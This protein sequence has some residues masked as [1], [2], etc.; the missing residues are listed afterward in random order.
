MQQNMAPQMQ[1]QQIHPQIPLQPPNPQ[2]QPHQILQPN[3]VAPP[4][5][6]LPGNPADENAVGAVGAEAP[7]AGAAGYQ[8]IADPEVPAVDNEVILLNTGGGYFHEMNHD[9][10]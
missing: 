6:T 2:M 1:N 3:Q 4:A 7:A 10:M 8:P 9:G 5:F